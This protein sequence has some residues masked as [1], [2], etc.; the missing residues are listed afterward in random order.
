ME[1][2]L[3][4]SRSPL[5]RRNRGTDRGGGARGRRGRARVNHARGRDANQPPINWSSTYQAPEPPPFNEPHPEPTSRFQD[6]QEKDYFEHLFNNEMWEIIVS[7]TNHYYEQQ[8]ASDP[9][10]HKTEWHPVTKGEVQALVGMLILMG[11]VRLPRFLMYWESDQLIH[12]ESI[13]NIMPRTRFFQI[14]RYFHLEDN[15][16][17]AAPGTVGHDK[18]YRI[19][20]FLTI[21]SRNVEREYRLSRDISIDETMVPHKGPLSFKQ[22][23]KNKPTRW[24]I[25]LWVLCEAETGYVYRFQVYLGKQGGHPETNLARRVVRDLTVTEHDRNHHLYMD[26]F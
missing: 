11:I 14:W 19:R 12:Q 23:I 5:A 18:I 25:K 2:D 16:K 1:N 20:N 7:E 17:A 15:S 4:R 10:H 13:A 6:V 3:S 22:Y 21:I 24:G 8:K 9:D 26:N